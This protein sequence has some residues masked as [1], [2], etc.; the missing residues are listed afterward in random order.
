[1]V[2]RPTVD[3]SPQ[4]AMY[5]AGYDTGTGD[6]AQVSQAGEGARPRG[7]GGWRGAGGRWLVWLFRVVLWLVLLVIG[8][9]G[10]MA[11]VLNETPPS[12]HPAVAA[13]K[14]SASFPVTK[15]DAFALEFAQVYLNASPAAAVQRATDLAQ[16]LPTGADPALGWNGKGTLTLQS[17][18]VAD[19][20][21]RNAHRAVVTLL[22]RV[23]GKLMELGVPVF[24]ARGG[25]V[26][27]GQPAWLPAPPRVSPPQPAGPPATD[28]TLQTTLMNQLP[29]FFQAYASGS[30]V[31]LARFLAPGSTVNGLDGEVTFGSLSE[32][33][34]PP[35]GTTRHVIATVE[36]RIPGQPT[37]GRPAVTAPPSAGLEMTY[38]LTIVKQN[39]TWYIENITSS[40]EA[41]GSP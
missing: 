36:W 8:Y 34:V 25:L 29:A 6:L 18:Q 37:G 7:P 11:I 38:A 40:T 5:S 9:R 27:S 16:F 28:T 31:T 35:G 30:R 26:V 24:Q 15:V 10:V 22:A 12:S 20:Q 2:R 14:Q 1:M 32:V 13:S 4:P 17:V 39:G 19:T 33:A 23:N 41:A 3:R 21:V